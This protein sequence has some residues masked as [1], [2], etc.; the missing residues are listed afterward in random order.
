MWCFR[1]LLDSAVQ[2]IPISCIRLAID[3]KI[4]LG[5]DFFLAGGF[6]Q[7]III[8]SRGSPAIPG[9]IVVIRT[10]ITLFFNKNL[11]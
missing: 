6:I 11:E 4:A 5:L 8:P 1:S 9:G 10:V 3:G 7:T 2:P